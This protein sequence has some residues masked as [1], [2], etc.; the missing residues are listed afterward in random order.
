MNRSVQFVAL[1]RRLKWTTLNRKHKAERMTSATYKGYVNDAM[2]RKQR[3]KIVTD[4]MH[5]RDEIVKGVV[6]AGFKAF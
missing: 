5:K 2:Q 1:L 3:P 6:D 4:S